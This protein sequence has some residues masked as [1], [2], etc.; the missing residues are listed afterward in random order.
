MLIFF[1]ALKFFNIEVSFISFEGAR[2]DERRLH[3]AEGSGWYLRCR[4]LFYFNIIFIK[5]RRKKFGRHKHI[6]I[7]K[8]HLENSLAIVSA[9]LSPR[10]LASALHNFFEYH[11]YP[12]LDQPNPSQAPIIGS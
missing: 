5:P 11:F 3:L 1:L 9:S 7:S 4:H 6:F 2:C 8:D 10:I 12:D